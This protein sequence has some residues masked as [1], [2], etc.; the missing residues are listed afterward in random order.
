MTLTRLAHLTAADAVG[1]FFCATHNTNAQGKDYLV[2]D[3]H[4]CIEP[5]L[6]ALEKANFN[7]NKDRLFSVGDLVDRG[8]QSAEVLG[9]LEKPW[10]YAVLGNHE[11]MLLTW[12]GLRDSDYHTASDF[13]RNGGDWVGRLSAA[14]KRRLCDEWLPRLAA[15]PYLRRINDETLPFYVVHSQRVRY[16]GEEM[17]VLDEHTAANELSPWITVATWGRQHWSGASQAAMARLREVPEA[18]RRHEFAGEVVRSTAPVL[19][20]VELTYCGHSIMPRAVLHHSHLHLD[21]G[22][23]R[24]TPPELVL[25]DHKVWAPNLA[26]TFRRG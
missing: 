15:L 6:R 16:F 9:L 11:G 10:F 1:A 2:G 21:L 23:Y 3:L 25:F 24:Q 19:D 5:L 17:R 20:G 12:A 7:P 14:G 8:P 4:G 22:L 18:W 13:F 26:E